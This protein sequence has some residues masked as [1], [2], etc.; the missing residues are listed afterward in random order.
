[1]A[2]H[3][4]AQAH[5]TLARLMFIHSN[6]EYLI[7]IANIKEQAL[8]IA[9][10]NADVT[11]NSTKIAKLANSTPSAINN[12]I[13][14]F[15]M[16]DIPQALV[17]EKVVMETTDDKPYETRTDFNGVVWM[18]ESYAK[19]YFTRPIEVIR[20]ESPIQASIQSVSH[21]KQSTKNVISISV[22]IYNKEDVTLEDLFDQIGVGDIIGITPITQRN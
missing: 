21:T 20:D 22:C 9:I 17:V 6:F 12:V 2:G 16:M 13:R 19:E 4:G 15:S 14:R 18:H 11:D 8:L 5:K 7:S 3:A 1:M 10:K